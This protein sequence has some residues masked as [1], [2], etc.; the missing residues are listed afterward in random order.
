MKTLSLVLASSLLLA[1]CTGTTQAPESSSAQAVSSEASSS[2]TAAISSSSAVAQSSSA[3]A[4]IAGDIAAGKDQYEQHCQLC[5]GENG[6]GVEQFNSPSLI[7]CSVCNNAQSFAHFTDIAMPP[8]NATAP[9]RCAG[10]CAVNVAAYAMATFNSGPD[11]SACYNGEPKASPSTFKRLSQQ[12]YANTLQALFQLD[13]PPDVSAIPDDPTVHNFKTIA[14]VQSVQ[15]SHL[16]GYIAVAGEQAEA[17]MNSAQRRE[18]VLGCDYNNA[19]CLYNFISDFGR[20]AFRRPLS[21]E[22]VNRIQQFAL[23][24]SRSTQ[25]QFTLAL[26]VM[27][28]SPNFIYRVEVGNSTEGLSTLNRYEL[29]SRLAFSLWGQGPTAELLDK[30]ENGELD[31]AEG[32]K[33]VAEEMLNDPRAKRHLTDFFEQWLATGLLNEP[34]DTPANWYDGIFDDM[35]AETNQLLN[36]Y[37]WE[38]K[39]F[40]NIFTENRS[41]LTPELANYYGLSANSNGDATVLPAG[42]PRAN[43]GLLTHAANMFAKTDGDLVAIRGNWLRGTFLCQELKLPSGVADIINGKFAGYTPMEIIAARNEDAACERCHAQIDPIGVAFAPYSREG[44]FDHGVNLADFPVTPGFPD[45][46]DA[47]ISSIQGMAAALA[48][49][50]E[51]GACLADRL[52]L[53]TRNRVPQDDDFC[54]VERASEQFQDSGRQ[55]ASLLLSLVDDPSFRVR[56]APEPKE[57]AEPEPVAINVASGKF[58]TASDQEAENPGSRL[59]DDI[60]TGDS[61]W[62]A[63]LFPQQAVIDLGGLHTVVQSEVYP[64]FER[65]YQFEISV[66]LD[67]NSYTRVVDRRDNQQ[68]GDV[69][70]DLFTPTDARYIR[71]TVLGTYGDIT[72]WSALREVKIFGAAK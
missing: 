49:M 58:V 37:V 28:S 50:P 30:A 40:M 63:Y 36:E 34:V 68:G 9:Q 22:E 20:L 6:E 1:A 12:E 46:G 54:A 33:A 19:G 11:R 18:R 5:H 70:R 60:L 21:S 3:P 72:E 29:A 35:R 57:V 55:F 16:S 4:V 67:G 27:L 15:V 56:V 66:S 64:Y 43:T 44:L 32:L 2:S 8:G 53:Y 17:L 45:A 13:T 31:S 69:I 48:D 71:V 23:G 25:E 41:Y 26:Q 38:G 52:F 10:D 14:S 61:R 65:P 51:V 47:S 39:D 42:N 59:V 7:G 24:N 62:S